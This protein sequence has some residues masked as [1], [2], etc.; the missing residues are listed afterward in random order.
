[1]NQTDD[2]HRYRPY[3]RHNRRYDDDYKQQYKKPNRQYYQYPTSARREPRN[4]HDSSY[5]RS[6]K[7]DYHYQS[8]KSKPYSYFS[9]PPPPLMST[10]IVPPLLPPPHPPP[11]PPAP[12][13]TIVPHERQSWIRSVK[14]TKVNESDEQKTQYLETMLRMPQQ[15]ASLNASKFDRMR[16]SDSH[17]SATSTTNN[18]SNEHLHESTF[19]LIDDVHANQ[20]I[21]TLEKILFDNDIHQQNQSVNFTFL[22]FFFLNAKLLFLLFLDE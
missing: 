7:H 10:P 18:L 16:F 19:Q 5:R 8:T 11:P 4:Y 12:S 2:N 17:L 13:V 14:R 6:Y 20:D 22:L 15:K 9:S 3:Y 1:M 21:R